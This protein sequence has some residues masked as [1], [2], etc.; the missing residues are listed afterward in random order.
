MATT[1]KTVTKKTTKD[2]S[3]S[4]KN[5]EGGFDISLYVSQKFSGEGHTVSFEK[6]DTLIL[7]KKGT[8]TI[9]SMEYTEEKI[10]F[11]GSQ[12][13]TLVKKLVE[14]KGK[15][16]DIKHFENSVFNKE[17][18]DEFSRKASYLVNNKNL[19]DAYNNLFK[20]AGISFV[21]FTPPNKESLPVSFGKITILNTINT[22]SSRKSVSKADFETWIKKNYS[23]PPQFFT[24]LTTNNPSSKYEKFEEIKIG[25]K[26]LGEYY[27]D[28]NAILPYFNLFNPESHFVFDSEPHQLIVD[29]IEAFKKLNP[30]EQDEK[31]I[32][33]MSILEAANKNSKSN[34]DNLEREI[35]NAST[36]I[37]DYENSIKSLVLSLHDKD[38]QLHYYKS[39]LKGNP[40]D[41]VNIVNETLNLPFVDSLYMDDGKIHIKM[42]PFFLKIPNFKR[43]LGGKENAGDRYTYL[44]DITFIIGSDIRLV[45]TKRRRNT[46][47]HY[48]QTPCFGH[49]AGREKIYNA[50]HSMNLPDLAKMLWFWANTYIPAS[51]YT[52]ARD[53]YDMCISNGI[54]VFDSEG[55]KISLNDPERLKSGEQDTL[56]QSD[57]YAENIKYYEGITF[58]KK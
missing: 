47:P 5:D 6:D 17:L 48:S 14:N 11:E 30:V 45:P 16:I 24:G 12:I 32:M 33:A 2:S 9:G 51:A 8:R 50:L 1:K 54:P 15:K 29:F 46:H 55:N 31:R 25:G 44:D 3:F 36:N 20:E 57:R 4:L 35:K 13:V 7:I 19:F 22:T 42:N 26:I 56:N 52:S 39:L 49:G 40:D 43:T 27:R 23:L 21:K 58:K 28:Y 18:F 38:E 37:R 53:W 10:K 41:F 34:I